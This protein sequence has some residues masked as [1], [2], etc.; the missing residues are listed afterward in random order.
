ML[1]SKLLPALPG[2]AGDV[3]TGVGGA[4]P[5]V[6][7]VPPRAPGAYEYPVT[8]LNKVQLLPTKLK[9]L[10]PLVRSQ[11]FRQA[12]ASATIARLAS[13]VMSILSVVDKSSAPDM[14]EVPDWSSA[15]VEELA[16][17]NSFM[18]EVSISVP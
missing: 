2:H 4:S 9:A 10:Q 6:Y 5:C 3:S 15:V 14:P 7:V 12:A 1:S 8:V 13:I 18:P 17:D 11:R 16:L